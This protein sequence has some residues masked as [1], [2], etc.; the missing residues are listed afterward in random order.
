M[1]IYYGNPAIWFVSLCREYIG[2]E[3]GEHFTYYGTIENLFRLVPTEPKFKDNPSLMKNEQF[4]SRFFYNE[5]LGNWS[6]QTPYMLGHAS[7]ITSPEALMSHPI[8]IITPEF[9]NENI[10][11]YIRQF[12]VGEGIYIIPPN[13]LLRIGEVVYGPSVLVDRDGVIDR[14]RSEY[15][16][17]DPFDPSLIVLR[18]NGSS[19]YGSYTFSEI[20]PD[21]VFSKIEQGGDLSFPENDPKRLDGLIAINGNDPA[22]LTENWS[23]QQIGTL[24]NDELSRKEGL[25]SLEVAG[26]TD[27]W[28][29]LG[30][31][32]DPEGVLD[33][34]GQ[35]LLEVWAKA[36][37]ETAFSVNLI[38][39][40]NRSRT[41][42]SVQEYG[43]SAT[44]EWKRF[45]I[46]LSNYTS[47]TPDFDITRVNFIDFYVSSDPGKEMSLWI[48]DLIVDDLPHLNEA[49]YK[50]R[51]LVED[52][53]SVYFAVRETPR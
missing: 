36:N 46:D 50:A 7:Y 6:G 53:V 2:A 31:R 25:A 43:S 26:V 52:T 45:V 16:Y 8:V 34:S 22:D 13:S 24:S 51:V 48:D 10:P 27:F 4:F 32:Y 12:Y 49:I 40:V 44:T 30:I 19:G 42:W 3:L 9:Y 11:Y 17:A 38:D 47:Q 37:E 39:A 41:F 14:V 35:P 21:W 1:V 33:L 20:P 23:T 29:N 18:V 28:G 5:L 15:L